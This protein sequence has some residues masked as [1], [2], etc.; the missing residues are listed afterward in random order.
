MIR[1]ALIEIIIK[2]MRQAEN[3]ALAGIANYGKDILEIIFL[4]SQNPNADIPCLRLP[5]GKM[6]VSVILAENSKQLPA[7][8]FRNFC[9]KKE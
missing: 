3:N 1:A 5:A 8:I 2:T 6:S 4:V 7:I 9:S